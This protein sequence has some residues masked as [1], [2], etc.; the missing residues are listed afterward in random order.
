MAHSRKISCKFG[1]NYHVLH[2]FTLKALLIEAHYFHF[3]PIDYRCN[4]LGLVLRVSLGRYFNAIP[5]GGTHT[6]LSL[7][8][9]FSHCPYSLEI[10]PVNPG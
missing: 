8:R 5:I 9:G 7:D 3:V 10:P 2:S 1:K 6:Q 4:Q